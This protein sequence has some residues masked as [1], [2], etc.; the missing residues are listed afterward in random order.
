[1]CKSPTRLVQNTH[2]ALLSS[3]PEGCTRDNEWDVTH[4]HEENNTIPE[5]SNS[6][7]Q[8]FCLSNNRNVNCIASHKPPILPRKVKRNK[9]P[10][11]PRTITA[12]STNYSEHDTTEAPKT[13][14][15]ILS[16]TESQAVANPVCDGHQNQTKTHETVVLRRHQRYVMSYNGFL[17]IYHCYC[18]MLSLDAPM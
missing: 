17:Y 7:S 3:T 16:A 12:L 9:P 10:V 1:M 18:V 13:G 11:P 6:S 15:Q 14:M 8:C 5:L 2:T 4:D